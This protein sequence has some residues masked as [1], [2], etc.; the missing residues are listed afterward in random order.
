MRRLLPLLF[1]LTAALF[2]CSLAAGLAYELYHTRRP[3]DIAESYLAEAER[4]YAVGD[5]AAAIS[6]L[7]VAAELSHDDIAHYRLYEAREKLKA[8][9]AP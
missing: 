5:Y 8:V 6:R 3:P 2:V 9:Q 1:R 4:L 7:R